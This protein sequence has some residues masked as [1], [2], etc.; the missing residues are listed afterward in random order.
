VR[1][2]AASNKANSTSLFPGTLFRSYSRCLPEYLSSLAKYEAQLRDHELAKLI[3]REAIGARQK[4]I[5]KT[6]WQLIGGMPE[7]TP[8]EQYRVEKIVY[9]TSPRLL[10]TANLYLPKKGNGLFTAVLFQIGH[11]WEAKACSLYQKCC[12]GLTA[13]LRCACV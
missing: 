1:A 2:T 6:F 5:R 12:Q 11:Y 4:W 10:V 9:E 13:R 7:R 8:R 3:P